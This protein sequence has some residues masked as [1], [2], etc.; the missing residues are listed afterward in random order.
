MK[1]LMFFIV[2][3]LLKLVRF[4]YKKV[5]ALYDRLQSEALASHYSKVVESTHMHDMVLCP[6][7]VYY[8]SQYVQLMSPHLQAIKAQPLWCMD[9][10]CGQ[11]R[12][13]FKLKEAC[14]TIS[15]TGVDLS[16]HA[17][18]QAKATCAEHKF[19]GLSFTQSNI[20]QYL[21]TQP[22]NTVDIVLFNEV[23]FFD[24]NYKT[25][26]L[27]AKRV[28]KQGG[29]LFASFRSQFYNLLW[30]ISQSL[31]LDVAKVIE[32]REGRLGSSSVVFTWL[33]SFELRELLREKLGLDLLTLSSIGSCSGIVGDPHAHISRPSA[34]DQEE[35][36][37]L[38]KA[39]MLIAD[40]IPDTGRYMFV[41]ARKK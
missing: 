36:A 30:M 39:E 12:L 1:K 31:W 23:A 21:E 13:L 29:L 26:L 17:I 9:L 40:Q 11:G 10:G 14:P 28:L 3:R 24:P 33:S 27:E 6:D 16:A 37:I 2:A 7:E 20:T 4:A 8:A 35:Q 19:S 41:A 38:M 5:L 15:G 22:D 25:V 32:K 18:S 34:L